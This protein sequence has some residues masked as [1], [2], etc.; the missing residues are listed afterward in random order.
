MK[1]LKRKNEIFKMKLRKEKNKLNL[2]FEILLIIHTF[3]VVFFFV[4][5]RTWETGK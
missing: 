3:I 1:N 5:K 2:K 4:E